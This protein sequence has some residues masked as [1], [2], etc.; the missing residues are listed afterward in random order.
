MC[1]IPVLDALG[2]SAVT[3][4]E[5]DPQ[6]LDG[7]ADELGSHPVVDV[8]EP[9]GCQPGGARECVGGRRVVV[10]Q[11]QGLPTPG[12]R[13]AGVVPIGGHVDGVHG[14]AI[15]PVPGVARRQVPVGAREQVIQLGDQVFGGVIGHRS[16]LQLILED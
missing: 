1:E 6:I 7:L 14:C 10:E 13:R 5:V 15:H 3:V 11:P 9:L 8:G 2:T 16:L 12:L 4:L